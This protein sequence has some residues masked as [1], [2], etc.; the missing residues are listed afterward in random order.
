MEIEKNEQNN[1]NSAQENRGNSEV[2]SPFRWI[3]MLILASYAI[4]EAVEDTPGENSKFESEYPSLYSNFTGTNS[5]F[6]QA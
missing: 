6:F 4:G 1:E 3:C 5:S 2:S